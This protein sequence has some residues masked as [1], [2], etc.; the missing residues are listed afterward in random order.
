[1]QFDEDDE[2]EKIC[3]TMITGI[4]TGLASL[5]SINVLVMTPAGELD[6][7]LAFFCLAASFGMMLMAVAMGVKMIS[8]M[9]R[10]IDRVLDPRR[11]PFL[12]VFNLLASV[13]AYLLPLVAGYQLL[14]VVRQL[15]QAQP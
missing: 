12:I 13:M 15:V 7:I 9:N 5:L 11:H 6:P 10:Y 14:H 2:L 8:R 4:G 3:R 1:M